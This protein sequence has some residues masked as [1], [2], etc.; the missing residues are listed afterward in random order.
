[1]ELTPEQLEAAYT[2]KPEVITNFITT[3]GFKVIPESDHTKFIDEERKR[4]EAEIAANKT[5]EIWGSLDKDIEDTL[6]IKKPADVKTYDF[7]KSILTDFKTSKQKIAD[8]EKKI[9]EGA[10]DPTLK[11][12]IE[13]L[14]KSQETLQTQLKDK[15]VLLFQ[16][17]VAYE[18]GEGLRDLKFKS[19][20]PK[21]V[22]DLHIKNIK[23]D[24]VQRAFSDNGNLVFK[25]EDGRVWLNDKLQSADAKFILGEILQEVI[26]KGISQPGAGSGQPTPPGQRPVI[27]AL[28]SD[29]NTQVKLGDYLMKN[30]YIQG[31]KE[32]DEI[33]FK[34][35]VNLPIK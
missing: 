21:S 11:T 30:G 6:G 12:Q 1:M 34:F 19:T 16:K 25:K 22:L 18:I 23:N 4:L 28:P 14:T 17:D 15:E 8:L 13:A 24:L 5:R 31:T 29:I 9:A 2:A 33:Y 32:Y 20:I 26:D 35:S 10:S 27:N 3:K 7:N